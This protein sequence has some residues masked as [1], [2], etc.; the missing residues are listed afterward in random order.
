MPPFPQPNP[1]VAGTA[2]DGTPERAPAAAD[3]ARR[4]PDAR[5]WQRAPSAS[6]RLAAYEADMR[7]DADVFLFGPNDFSAV[8][9]GLY[10]YEPA[11]E[12]T[13]FPANPLMPN[14][15]AAMMPGIPAYAAPPLGHLGGAPHAFGMPPY[16]QYGALPAP[17]EAVPPAA[18]AVIQPAP[19]R[20][21]PPIETP[22]MISITQQP[23]QFGRFRYKVRR[24]RRRLSRKGTPCALMPRAPALLVLARWT[25]RARTARPRS[26]ARTACRRS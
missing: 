10:D 5:A 20:I 13:E 26:R 8:Q 23:A 19:E 9:S 6:G 14:A 16:P 21:D 12:P 1:P 24:R 7:H 25:A 22:N 3:G 4:F 15:P 11:L 2:Y 17:P 18:P